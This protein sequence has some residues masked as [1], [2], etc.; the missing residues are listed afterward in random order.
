SDAALLLPMVIVLLA[1][2]AWQRRLHRRLLL[3]SAAGLLLALLT[4]A[5]WL[6]R[7]QQ[8]F[9]TPTTPHLS[10]MF[11]LTDHDEHFAY[12]D[13]FTLTTLLQ[14]QTPAQLISKRL[15]E[16]AAAL[17][18]M[19]VS[20]D[21]LLP[22]AVGG[23]LLLLLA[24]RDAARG[25]AIAP[26]L[27]LLGGLLVFYPVLIPMKSQGGSF[28]KAYLAL[29]PLLLPLAGYALEQAVPDRRLRYGVMGLTLSLLA[30][31]AVDAVRLDA[32]FLRDYLAYSQQI[33]TTAQQLPDV[34]GDG[35]M[36]LMTRDPFMMRFY[37]LQSVMT[38]R[39]DREA[40]LA[41]A[42]R[43]H[44]DYVLAPTARP[45]LDEVFSGQVPDERFQLVT[46]LPGGLSFW[47]FAPEAR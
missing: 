38:P 16:L 45:A 40:V 19:V 11:F 25:W 24:R 30:A 12:D 27:I 15:F 34:T 23:G 9:G 18:T 35:Q 43:Y 29:I 3:W 5:P 33:V 26:V 39:D 7:N 4:V 21:M 8:L 10:R 6:L 41:V 14:S 47:R 31:F 36:R 28:K 22:V 20:L 37:G 13:D 46:T 2:L 42:R 17:K 1:G 32:Q 44:I